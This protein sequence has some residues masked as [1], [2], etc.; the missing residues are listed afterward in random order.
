MG[1]AFLPERRTSKFHVMFGETEKK[2]LGGL[3]PNAMTKGKGGILGNAN[4]KKKGNSPRVRQVKHKGGGGG[5]QVVLGL[6]GRG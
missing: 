4:L 6:E 5:G 3:F 1:N 2:I